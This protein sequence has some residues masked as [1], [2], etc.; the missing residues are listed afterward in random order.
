MRHAKDLIKV[1][2][3]GEASVLLL[4]SRLKEIGIP[5]LIKND[6]PASWIGNAPPAIDLYIRETDLEESEPVIRDFIRNNPE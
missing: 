1:F 5:S 2:A 3:G 6:S 4:K